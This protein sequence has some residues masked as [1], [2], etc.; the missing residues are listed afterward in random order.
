M[1]FVSNLLSLRSAFSCGWL[2]KC[3]ESEIIDDL[4]WEL[5]EAFKQRLATG[6][7]PDLT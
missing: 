4:F 5:K 2:A 7:L 1:E 6:T 3:W